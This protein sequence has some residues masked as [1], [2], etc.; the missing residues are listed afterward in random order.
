MKE[1]ISKDFYKFDGT[2]QELQ[3]MCKTRG[4]LIKK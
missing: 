4:E 2:V 3:D 1:Y